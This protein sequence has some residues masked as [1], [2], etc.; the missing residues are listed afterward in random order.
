MNSEISM[1]VQGEVANTK[2]LRDYA[3]G[4]PKDIA[5]FMVLDNLKTYKN[6]KFSRPA[7]PEPPRKLPSS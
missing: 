3:L 5:D 7:P 4:P 1:G 6:Q 2:F